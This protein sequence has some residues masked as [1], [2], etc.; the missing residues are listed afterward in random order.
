MNKTISRQLEEATARIETILHIGAMA[1]DDDCLPTAL[2]D[3]LQDQDNEDLQRLFPGL[4]TDV[5]DDFDDGSD[6]TGFVDWLRYSDRLGFLVQFATPV[7]RHHD[8]GGCS[9]SWGH[10]GTRWFYAETLEDA[11]QQGLAWVAERRAKEREAAAA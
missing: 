10:Y 1:T 2:E 4:P 6:P 7:I 11:V 3:M 8:S 9:Y 5:L